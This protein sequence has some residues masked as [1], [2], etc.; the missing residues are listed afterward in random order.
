M[1]FFIKKYQNLSLH[2]RACSTEN[3]K[4]RNTM[5]FRNSGQNVGLQLIEGSVHNITGIIKSLIDEWIHNEYHHG[6]QNN[7]KEATEEDT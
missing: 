4:C 7:V 1:D 2:V 6:N 3:D 5:N